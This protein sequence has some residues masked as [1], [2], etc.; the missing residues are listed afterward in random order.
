[1]AMDI[2]LQRGVVHEATHDVESFIWVF[3]YCVMRNILTRAFEDPRSEVRE[4]STEFLEIFSSAF[5]QTAFEK[6]TM[7]RHQRCD[8]L[9]FPEDPDVNKIIDSFM[10]QSLFNL[11]LDIRELVYA[12]EKPGGGVPLTHEKLLLVVDKAIDSL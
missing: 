4:Q 10:S 2:L 5:A 6:I 3:S 11:F 7:V 1:M 8:A 12:L 9:R